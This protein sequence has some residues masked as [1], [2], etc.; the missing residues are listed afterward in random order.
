MLL[1]NTYNIA[2]DQTIT[3]A[4]L[5]M[6]NGVLHPQERMNPTFEK[7]KTYRTLMSFSK[8]FNGYLSGPTISLRSFQDL[9]GILYFDLTNQEEE[10]KV[11]QPSL[12][13]NILCLVVQM[14][15]LVRMLLFCMRKISELRLN[16]KAVLKA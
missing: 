5:E 7:V 6:S 16:G 2:N 9:Y 15:D 1:F 11:D 14:L 8:G 13:S 10:L 4:Q 12:N 3:S